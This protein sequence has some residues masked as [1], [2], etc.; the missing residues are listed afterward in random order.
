MITCAD[1]IKNATGKDYSTDE[2]NE[3]V[4]QAELL[5]K[6]INLNDSIANK[7][8]AIQ[9]ALNDATQDMIEE[10]KI[11]KRNALLNQKRQLESID[12]VQNA[13]PE[14]IGRGIQAII[15]GDNQVAYGSRLSVDA[16]QKSLSGVYVG[17]MLADL[18]KVGLLKM[19]GSG[20]LDRDIARHMWGEDVADSNARSIGDIYQKYQEMSRLDA[21]Q[22]GAW[23][24]K[25]PN[26][27]TRQSHDVDK[28]AKA[29]KEEWIDFTLPKLDERTF[30]GVEDVQGF[31]DAVYK[32]LSS[33][34]HKSGSPK[35]IEDAMK[36]FKGP[37]NV[38]KRMSQGRVLHFKNADSFMDYND[39][40]GTSSLAESINM[41]LSGAAESTG[42]M[43][44]L[45]TNP[46]NMVDSIYDNFIDEF[47]NLDALTKS[48]GY[49]SNLLKVAN[50]ET[51]MA[52]SQMF[53]A[54]MSATRNWL[55]MSKLG[56]ALLSSIG[57]DNV[58]YAAEVRYQGGNMFSGLSES[59]QGVL[60]GRQSAD[61][62]AI[63]ANL[64]ITMDSFAGTLASRFNVNDGHAGLTQKMMTQFFRWNGLSWWTD[65][66]KISAAI[67]MSNR[68]Y[69][70]KDLPFEKID[71]RL[72]RVMKLYGIEDREWS[73]IKQ[74]QQLDERG[75][76]LLTPE[77]QRD[78]PDQVFAESLESQGLKASKVAIRDYRI[79]LE[80]KL[81]SYVADRQGFAVL[82]GDT[83]SSA[84]WTQGTQRG[85][86]EGE[87]LRSIGQFKQF[88][89][90]F[91]QRVLGRE[92]TGRMKGSEM[93]IDKFTD[94]PVYGVVSLMVALAASGYVS[95][96]AKDIA[97]GRTPREFNDDPSNN[98]K[99]A[100]AAMIQ[101]GGLGIYGDFLFGDM[102]RFGGGP[103]DT[104]AGPTAGLGGDIIKLWQK[105]K[106]GDDPSASA[107]SL[108]LNNTP[109]LNLFYSRIVLDYLF[110]YDVRESLNP[111]YMKRMEKRIEKENNQEFLYPPSRHAARPIQELTK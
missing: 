42:L 81:R 44:K 11:E 7:E 39:T 108:A 82:E 10:A 75:T 64:G 23:I 109:G 25:D 69:Q 9:K 40:F 38:A 46:E 67:G 110:L 76:G 73:I 96:S 86:K 54:N 1:A 71:P 51:R 102:S 55:S 6:R 48:K 19:A 57:A 49:T 37:G 31:M 60:K 5:K 74:G 33:G 22:A 91:V 77:A 63:A 70:Q 92:V 32:G 101:G 2:V 104:L 111:G 27:I 83:R 16:E 68:L 106:N 85:T 29:T 53:A 84:T 17:G 18:D 21:N 89:T 90:I 100:A 14:D 79:E 3:F 72:K 59:L 4:R 47:E 13:F 12:F 65:S 62:R 78:I 95:M 56:G 30:D 61:Q 28:I 50:G 15:A 103:I 97:K 66:L 8:E 41:S 20:E 24:K 105:A 35:S 87:L 36:Q 88:P 43:R 107:V 93:G 98:F 34:I 99:I 58:A 45:G 26:Y 94:S 52:G 80:S